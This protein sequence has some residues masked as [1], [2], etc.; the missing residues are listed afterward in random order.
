[1]SQVELNLNDQ[2]SCVGCFYRTEHGFHRGCCAD[3]CVPDD[4]CTTTIVYEKEYT[5]E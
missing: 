1:M 4:I 3:D 2:Q 5:D